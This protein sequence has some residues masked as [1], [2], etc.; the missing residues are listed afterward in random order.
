MAACKNFAM[1]EFELISRCVLTARDEL[2]GSDLILFCADMNRGGPR[3]CLGTIYAPSGR[4]SPMSRCAQ[5]T[6]FSPFSCLFTRL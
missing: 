6:A 1:L 5:A 2:G 4:R 3:R